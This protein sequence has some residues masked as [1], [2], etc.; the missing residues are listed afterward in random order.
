MSDPQQAPGN[1]QFQLAPAPVDERL[2]GL[3]QQIVEKAESAKGDIFAATEEEEVRIMTLA[4]RYAAANLVPWQKGDTP[5]RQAHRAFC[6]MMYAL[7]LKLPLLSALNQIAVVNNKPSLMQKLKLGL[8][9][10]RVKFDKRPWKEEEY[11][12][13]EAE[14]SESRVTWKCV[15]DGVEYVGTFSM[16]DARRAGLYPGRDR[17]GKV[18]PEAGWNKYP[19][20]YLSARAC[21]RML[22]IACADVLL[23]VDTTEEMRDLAAAEGPIP[24]RPPMPAPMQETLEDE[25][26]WA[27]SKTQAAST[28]G[29]AATGGTKNEESAGSVGQAAANTPPKKAPPKAPTAKPKGL[30]TPPAA[31]AVEKKSKAATSNTGTAQRAPG[32][33]PIDLPPAT[34]PEPQ[35]PREAFNEKREK[36]KALLDSAPAPGLPGFDDMPEPA[37]SREEQIAKQ[38][39]A[40]AEDWLVWRCLE[41]KLSTAQVADI[42]QKM[43]ENRLQG[44]WDSMPRGSLLQAIARAKY[45]LGPEL[46]K[47]L[48]E[49]LDSQ[50]TS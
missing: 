6:C 12:D 25:K 49:P 27:K 23:G 30:P 50:K 26:E 48:L 11:D 20:D 33:P 21:G 45:H 14:D 47:K 7:E 44:V 43:A 13:I 29:D 22:D 8:C 2:A 9:L 28:A 42:K 19:K 41:V 40:N 18:S 1:P 10:Q 17:D 24:D 4:K 15:R 32:E 34:K 36:G 38:R 3:L 35:T 39:A 31:P 16:Q 37:T 46:T 5:E